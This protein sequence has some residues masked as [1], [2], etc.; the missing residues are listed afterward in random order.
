MLYQWYELGHVAVNPARMAADAARFFCTNPFN[1]MSH[2]AVGRQTAAACEV[3][4][5]STR[6]YR[7]PSFGI[8]STT[9]G[10]MTY[11]VQER[12]V[13]Q[14]PFCRLTHFARELPPPATN[15]HPRILLVA[16]MSGHFAT[17]LRGT[18]EALLPRHDVYITEW[19]DAREVPLS[20][21]RFD[22]DTYIDYIR[23]MLAYF[24]GN[25]SVFAVCQPSVPV[26]AAISLMEQDNDPN[27]PHSMILAGGPIDTR[28]N[29]TAVNQLAEGKSVDWF[30]DTVITTVPWPNRGHGRAVY[31]GFLQLTGFMTMN[32]DRHLEAHRNLFNHLIEGD[33]DSAEKHRNFYD[34]YLAVMDMTAEFY[35]QTVETVFIRHALAKGEMLH[36]GRKVDPGS[37]TRVALMTIEGE[38]DDITGL[39]QCRAAHDLCTSIPPSRKVHFEAPR[40][41]HYGIFNGTRFR[42]EIVPRI[43]DF[44][45]RADSAYEHLADLPEDYDVTQARARARGLTAAPEDAAFTFRAANDTTHDP[46]ARRLRSTG[47]GRTSSPEAMDALHPP[48]LSVLQLWSSINRIILEGWIQAAFG[49]A[50]HRIAD[51]A[52]SSPMHSAGAVDAVPSNMIRI[53]G[54]H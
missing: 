6:R 20:S 23:E 52:T 48:Q 38:K 8:S 24:G 49:P 44:V 5:R 53:H 19:I 50:N 54:A 1:P 9:E 17:L 34:E 25:V 22:L 36:R 3:F 42:D 2:T 47:L 11:P 46:A 41:G 30:R 14:K 27:V 39:G 40:V 10:G 37:I 18:V 16:P 28:V 32:L 29:P 7:R 35:L 33:G 4:E 31:P 43:A 21:G 26:L 15:R 12:V 51:T 45:R 13:W